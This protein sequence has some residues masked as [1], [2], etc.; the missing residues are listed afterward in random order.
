[1]SIGNF[2]ARINAG[3]A[4]TYGAE[5]ENQWAATDALQLTLN[6]GYLEAFYE[7]FAN[8]GGP[9]VDADDNRMPYSPRW[10]AST[11]ASYR[12]PV[13]L[14]GELSFNTDLQY[15][16][17]STTNALNQ[18]IYELPEQFFWNAN[19]RYIT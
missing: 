16:A 10:T 17:R 13:N 4:H 7:R 12:L 6:L 5:L 1:P 9:G 14:P 8:A 19:L 15:Q 3:G 11:A 18:P 2:Y